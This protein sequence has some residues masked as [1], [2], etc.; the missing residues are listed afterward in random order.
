[1]HSIIARNCMDLMSAATGMQDVCNN[2]T[3]TDLAQFTLPSI[4]LH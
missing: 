2:N 4:P 3:V 1:M